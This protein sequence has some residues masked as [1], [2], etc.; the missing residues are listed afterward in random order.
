MSTLSPARKIGHALGFILATLH[1]ASLGVPAPDGEDSPP[2]AVLLVGAALGI[3]V[4]VLLAFSW[5]RD[6]RTPRRIAAVLLV[7][8]ALG[9]VPGMLVSD[10]AVALQIAAGVLVLLTIATIVLLFLPPRENV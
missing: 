8:A 1:V 2:F 4:I 6:S 10:V 7:I 3:V 9:A 5:T